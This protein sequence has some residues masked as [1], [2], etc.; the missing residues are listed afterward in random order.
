MFLYFSFYLFSPLTY[1]MD[2][3]TSDTPTNQMN[4]LRWLES[5]EF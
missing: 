2:G 5:W 4:S 3:S 1:G